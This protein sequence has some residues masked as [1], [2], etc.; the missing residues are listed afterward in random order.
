MFDCNDEKPAQDLLMTKIHR[1]TK[2]T[3][4]EFAE[5]LMLEG[6][7]ISDD[8]GTWEMGCGEEDDKNI[9]TTEQLYDKFLMTRKS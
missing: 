4:I 2:E 5:W 8:Y 3:A 6:W 7:V 9:Y 1:T